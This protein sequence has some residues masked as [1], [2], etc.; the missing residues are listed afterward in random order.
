MV[1]RPDPA[2]EE[3][4]PVEEEQ[5]AE[6]QLAELY[7]IAGKI[8][9]PSALDNYNALSGMVR[10]FSGDAQGALSYFK[11]NINPE[12]YQ[13]YAYFK[14]LALKSTGEDKKAK[15]IFNYIANYN[16]NSWEAVLVRSLAK[17]QLES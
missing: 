3:E 2:E 10:L 16:F 4:Q 12:N 11:D 5:P 7:P 14:G 1:P 17:K 9:S 13:Y 8:Q 15:A 6:E